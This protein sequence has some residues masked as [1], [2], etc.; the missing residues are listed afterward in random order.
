MK[1]KKLFTYFLLLFLFQ[2]AAFAQL[3]QSKIETLQQTLDSVLGPLK[4]AGITVSAKVIHAETNKTLYEYKPEAEMIPASI[5]K[6]ITAACALSKLG[7]S[8]NLSTV[9]YTDDSN[10]GDG[11]I[12]G[13]L[14]LKG[15]G[16]PDFSS[17]DLKTLADDFLK[18]GI[19]EVTGNIIADESFFDNDYYTL[20]NSYKG[21]TGPSYWPY[22]CGLTLDKNKGVG[23]SPSMRAANDLSGYLS[24]GGVKLG[25]STIAGTTPQGSKEIAKF[26]HTIFDV[27]A[28]MLKESDNHSAITM[29]KLVGAKLIDNPGSISKGQQAIQNFLT[30]LG[31]NRYAYEILEGSGLTRYNKVSAD[32]YIKVLKYMYD[33]R[34]LFDYFM[35]ALSVAGKDGTLRNRMVGTEA[36][37]NVFAKTGTLNGVS[38]LS[39]YVIDKESEVLIFYIVMNGFGGN[40]NSMRSYQDDFAV[41]LA[42]FSGK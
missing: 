35:N 8:Y 11:V 42:G 4:T 41:T 39:G 24:A 6:L 1:F 13:N 40:A 3:K 28:N 18:L 17:S 30:E 32:V 16:D 12:N 19:K 21:D 37:G 38:A 10:I 34:F 36:E 27:L 2:T 5:T 31:V 20:S 15:Y 23:G 26:N 25:G 29:F 33:D 22:I 7:Q 9:L 14:Y